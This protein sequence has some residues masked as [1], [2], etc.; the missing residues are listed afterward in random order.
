MVV[1]DGI[2]STKLHSITARRVH[3]E[4]YQIA[5]VSRAG[6]V[7]MC[8]CHI[9]LYLGTMIPCDVCLLDFDTEM[10]LMLCVFRTGSAESFVDLARSLPYD[11]VSLHLLVWLFRRDGLSS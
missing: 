4:P 9:E 1:T 5:L 6:Q 8:V 7:H 10:S 3:N 11:L 2:R